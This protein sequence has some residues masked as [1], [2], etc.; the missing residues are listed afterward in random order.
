MKYYC[1]LNTLVP[2]LIVCLSA[3]I[4]CGLNEQDLSRLDR[5]GQR[6]YQQ[7][8]YGLAV[9]Y[10]DELLRNRPEDSEAHLNTGRAYMHLGELRKAAAHFS[11]SVKF[12]PESGWGWFEPARVDLMLGHDD[13]GL[14]RIS[15]ARK[16][17]PQESQV[18]V[19]EGDVH[20]F[21]RQ[22]K[23]AE[24]SYRQ[25]HH[26]DAE[27]MTALARLALCL[28]VQ[29]RLP[30]SEEVYDTLKKQNP[31]DALIL[32]SMA[33]YWMLRGDTERAESILR[34]GLRLHPD[35]LLF[36]QRLVEWAFDS[37]NPAE[38]KSHVHYILQRYPGN[39]Y[40]TKLLIEILLAEGSL[41]AAEAELQKLEDLPPDDTESFLLKGKLHLL[42]RRPNQAAGFFQKAIDD[43]PKHSLAHYLKG[44]ALLQ[45]GHIYLA[46]KRFVRALA[47]A[48]LYTE[49]ELALAG[50][51]L[52][53]DDLSTALEYAE[54]VLQREPVN[55]RAGMIQGI[56]RLLRADY[57]GAA[58]AFR[59]AE[60]LAPNP[61]AARYFQA[62]TAS[63]S[64]HAD[65]ALQL[66]RR[67]LKQNPLYADVSRA[68][69]RLLAANDRLGEAEAFFAGLSHMTRHAGYASAFLG[70]IHK[71]QGDLEQ[72]EQDWLAAL[73]SAS[74]PPAVY[75][76]LAG[77]YQST[78]QPRRE[79]AI[80]ERFLAEHPALS[81][82]ALQLAAHYYETGEHEQ[83]VG[84]LEKSLRC[85]P[86]DP[87]L[88]SN[89]AWLLLQKD[90]DLLRALSLAQEAY[91]RAPQEPAVVDTL[92]WAYFKKKLYTRAVWHL[93][94]ALE[95]DPDHPEIRVHLDK[96]LQAQQAWKT[97]GRKG[98]G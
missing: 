61:D 8:D 35:D 93:E 53:Q 22:Y 29:D 24:Q 82:A 43:F 1:T 10:W 77:L 95:L 45:Q 44:A 83:A 30:E 63:R 73:E 70:T 25:A 86:D 50:V 18:V 33:D 76:A 20:L 69:T 81:R 15:K 79:Q 5:S 41:H 6:A 85:N 48:P 87:F 88:L 67:I 56:V 71:I 66:Y 19:L 2:L 13:K 62:E 39:Y 28:A 96:A 59:Q 34:Q 75:S 4:G 94:E 64:G 54:R 97:K 49:A 90:S 80:L 89:V 47:L 27:N 31:Q 3:A 21:R 60:R 92:G 52:Y 7:R 51:A 14:Q 26:M 78:E 37:G 36:A 46:R 9:S 11:K 42:A 57:D 74:C 17:L 98:G 84:V 40:A 91:R 12:D 23:E 38:A 58:R 68:Y 16:L 55:T 72:A 65:Q 32:L